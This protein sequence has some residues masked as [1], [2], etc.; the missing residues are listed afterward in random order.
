MIYSKSDWCDQITDKICVLI[1]CKAEIM[2]DERDFHGALGDSLLRLRMRT[3][4]KML[5]AC[6]M[7]GYEWAV[8]QL[9]SGSARRR[10]LKIL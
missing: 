2:Q 9:R 7:V 6:S 10:A 5:S 1:A 4:G 8:A 3:Q